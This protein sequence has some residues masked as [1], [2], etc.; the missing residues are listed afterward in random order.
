VKATLRPIPSDEELKRLATESVL[1]LNQAV[2]DK[3]FT[4]F[5]AKM[6]SVVK[7]STSPEKLHQLFQMLIDKE[8][9]L[10]SIKEVT[11]V[12]DKA[13]S[14]NEKDL[15]VLSGYFPTKTWRAIF[16]LHYAYE[17]PNWK[18]VGCKLH[19]EMAPMNP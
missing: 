3:D 18:L 15:L 5:H 7:H 13:P 1:D 10:S 2:K 14:L 17:H 19:L 8:M 12:F 9:D 4:A 11:P 16:L 6:A